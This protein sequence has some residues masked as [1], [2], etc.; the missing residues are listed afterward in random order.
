M[1]QRDSAGRLAGTA[2]DHAGAALLGILAQVPDVTARPIGCSEVDDGIMSYSLCLRL[3]GGRE[4]LV[5]VADIQPLT[6][7]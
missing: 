1:A 2:D 5:D 6:L 4:V 7:F 3:P